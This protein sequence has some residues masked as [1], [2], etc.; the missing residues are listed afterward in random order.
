M[1][2]LNSIISDESEISDELDESD[3]SDEYDKSN[4]DN[5]FINNK[6]DIDDIIYF[7]NNIINENELD[8]DKND[9]T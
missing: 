8:F 4:K 5:I 3:E 9:Y 7:K 2:E 1:N 6:N